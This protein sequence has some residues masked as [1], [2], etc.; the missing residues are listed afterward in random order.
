RRS[1]AATADVHVLV[2]SV[3]KNERLM[4]QFGVVGYV[5]KPWVTKA[6]QDELRR[7]GQGIKRRRDRV[8]VLLVHRERKALAPLAAALVEEG[9]E[10][11]RAPGLQGRLETARAAAPDRGGPAPP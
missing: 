6:M 5:A 11:S 8:R 9:F 10:V 2:C 3:T 1:R 7:V 4:A